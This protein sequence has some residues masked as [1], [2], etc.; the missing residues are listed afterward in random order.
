MPDQQQQER[1]RYQ[2]KLDRRDAH[3]G[4][5]IARGTLATPNQPDPADLITALW[6]GFWQQANRFGRS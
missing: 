1:A 2:R 3:T 5:L 4:S 6:L